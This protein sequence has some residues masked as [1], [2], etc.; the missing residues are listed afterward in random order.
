VDPTIFCPFRCPAYVHV[1]KEQ[2]ISSYHVTFDKARVVPAHELAPWNFPTVEGQWRD[3]FQG[4]TSQRI[5]TPKRRT[6]NS[7]LQTCTEQL[8][9][10]MHLQIF[11]MLW[12]CNNHQVLPLMTPQTA[13]LCMGPS[14]APATIPAPILT[15][16]QPQP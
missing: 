12:R 11:W 16:V 4:N 5:R 13:K 9:L 10:T 1:P 2:F 6:P 7:G 15:P 8:E 14:P 3:Y